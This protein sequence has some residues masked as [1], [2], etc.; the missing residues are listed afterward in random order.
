MLRNLAADKIITVEETRG[1]IPSHFP[2]VAAKQP[3]ASAQAR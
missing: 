1:I 3:A 2:R